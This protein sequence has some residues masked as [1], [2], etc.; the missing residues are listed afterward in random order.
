MPV[1]IFR[2]Y[3]NLPIMLLAVVE[4][5]GLTAIPYLAAL[6]R[7][8][9]DIQS[10]EQSVGWLAP[11]AVLF[12]AVA[13]TCMVAMGLYSARQRAKTTGLVVRISASLVLAT[14]AMALLSYLV[15][16]VH[17]GRGVLGIAAV[18]A[19]I[20]I[21]LSRV[22]FG[23]L[24][25]D[26]VFK[27][28]VLIYGVGRQAQSVSML[29]RRADQ[30]GFVVVGYVPSGSDRQ[31]VPPER[32]AN[33]ES[34]LLD[35]ARRMEVDEIIVAMDDRRREFP[36]HQLLECR[37]AGIEVIDVVTFLERETG[38]VRLDV[39]NPSWI[40]FSEGFR[41]DSVRR[42]SERAFDLLAASVLVVLTW[43]IMLL[44]AL[45]ILIEDGP[46]ASILYRQ[47]RVGLDGRNF[48]V[49]KFR[50]MRTDAEQD[51]QARWAQSSDSRVTRVG[52][53]I[54]KL[55]I[56][57]LPQILNVLRGD[58]SFVGPRPERP[59]FVNRLSESIPYYRERHC[60]KPGI[61]GWAQLCYPYGSSEHDATEKLQY[62]L[63]YVKNHSLLFDLMILLQ[64][65]EVVL[66]GKGAR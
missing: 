64:T 44:T 52:A 46:R 26:E 11:R 21:G 1:R 6:L 38:K 48:Q 58:M 20:F 19:L 39:L 25:N 45:A 55:R 62:D 57:E 4:A 2:H 28:R 51:G 59:E 43:W 5:V 30:R 36:V 47:I 32:I 15:P 49:L 8:D 14:A 10:A 24:V 50:S 16:Q 27:R 9:A 7:F 35:Y 33:I 54:R 31:V 12:A 13:M 63:Y 17:I 29:R 3:V 37:L 40:I 34:S 23:R 42:V 41:R 53:C 61:T 18:G 56:D 22:V 66:L 60:V 65:A